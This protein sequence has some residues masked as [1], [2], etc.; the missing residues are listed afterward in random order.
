[1][2]TYYGVHAGVTGQFAGVGFPPTVGSEDQ[3]Q[4]GIRCSY[5]LS[6]LPGPFIFETRSHSICPAVLELTM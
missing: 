2:Y 6:H 3:T 1:M 4:V 5:P